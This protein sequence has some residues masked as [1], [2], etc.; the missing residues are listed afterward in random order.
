M[1]TTDEAYAP[2]VDMTDFMTKASQE[3]FEPP[4][5]SL[6]GCCSIQLSYWDKKMKRVKGIEP[7]TSAWK[8]E[9]LPLNY[10]RKCISDFATKNNYMHFL[11]FC[12][13]NE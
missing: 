5:Y 12:Q 2:I 3:G 9:V 8:A 7:S 6:E 11:L 4:T 10:T 13:Q 1:T